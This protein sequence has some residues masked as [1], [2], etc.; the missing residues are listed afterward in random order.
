MTQTMS[1]KKAKRMSNRQALKTMPP[2][3]SRIVGRCHVGESNSKVIRYFISRLKHKYATW[4]TIPREQRREW[5]Q[6]VIAEHADNRGVYNS[7]I[8]GI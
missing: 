2:I 3:V 6:W 1:I 5:L 7:V 4:R 8:R